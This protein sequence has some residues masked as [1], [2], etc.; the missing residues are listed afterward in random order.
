MAAG[1]PAIGM[2]EF[3]PRDERTERVVALGDA[4]VAAIVP[5]W[6]HLAELLAS[7]RHGRSLVGQ[8]AVGPS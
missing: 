3:V 6:R 2:L 5:S 8:E 7:G 4:G 1:F